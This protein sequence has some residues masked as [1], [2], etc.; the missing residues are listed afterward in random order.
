MSACKECGSYA[1]NHHCHGRDGT[2][3]DLCDVCY[4]KKRAERTPLSED[5]LKV[6]RV[7]FFEDNGYFIRS[8]TFAVLV[9]TIEHLHEIK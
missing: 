4:W 3:G 7:K 8:D 5:E 6:A 2:D 1:I 9:R